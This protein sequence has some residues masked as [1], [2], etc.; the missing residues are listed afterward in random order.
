MFGLGLDGGDIER[1]DDD[2]F[3]MDGIDTGMDD[4]NFEAEE[5]VNLEAF[6]VPLRE[7]IAQDRT[8][9]EIQRKF[10][11]FVSTFREGEFDMD[12]DLHDDMHEAEVKRRKRIWAAKSP[13]YEDKIRIMCAANKSA[14]EVNYVHLSAK[15]PILALWINEAPKDM[16]DVLNEAATR[17]TLRLFPSYHTIRDEIHV[18]ISDVPLADSLRDMRHTHLDNLVKVSGVITRRSGVFPQLKLAYYDCVKCKFTTGPF[19]IE[20]STSHSSGLDGANRDVSDVHAPASCPE[21]QSEGPFRINSTRSRYRNYQRI[22]LQ[23]RPGS[24]PPG[25]VPRTK[26]VVFLDDLVD[27]A[28]PGEEVE[29]TGVFCHSYDSLLTQRSGFPV[30][31]TYISA[32][33]VRK[34]EDASSAANLSESDRKEILE[35]ARDTNIGKRIVQSIAPSIYGHDHV[36]MA[37]AMALFGAV[38]KNVD[39]KHRIRGD[40]NVLILGDPGTAKSQMLKYAEATAPRAVYST[41]KGASAVGLTANVHKDPL[42]REWTLEGGALVLADRGVCLIDEFDKMNEQDRTSIHEAMEQQTI[43]VSKAGIVTSLQARCSVI[44][45]ANPI[46]GRYDSSCTLAEN[47]ELT[48]PILQRFDCLCVLQDLVDPVAD[49]RLSSFVTKTHAT[50]IPTS[51]VARGVELAPERS[52]L[53]LGD[54]VGSVDLIPQSLLRKYIQYA[55]ANCR[56]ALRG[57]T[58]DQEK[59]ASLYVQ[60][61]K[62]STNSGGVPIAV[63]HI[64][65]IM[66]MAEAH[67]KMHLRDYVRDDDMDASIRI[68]LESFISAQK[69]SVR[70]TLR[71][72]F[73]K[74]LSSGEDRVHLLLHILQDMMRNEAMYQTI[75]QRQR[76][77]TGEIENLEVQLDEFEGKARERRIYDV[78]EFCKSDAFN[79]AGYTLD[80]SKRVISRKF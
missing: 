5:G 48:D 46:G 57:G 68:M 51:E 15:E 76:G 36:K 2:E 72:S 52:S 70:R 78:A 35:L 19:R 21:C 44:A 59:I 10:R 43:S 26:E 23:E 16:F 31:Q 29:I 65:S 25:R 24:I 53:E 28:R 63:R 45:A 61:R 11:V 3:G 49:E 79:E 47:V 54:G 71:R 32:N 41:G 55:R 42:T 80:F 4:D 58:F 67:A 40:V 77:E 69:F 64:E 1:E 13:T 56:P 34:K 27:C 73:G 9:R 39:D 60:L 17:H 74:F 8:R 38:P 37:L 75:R 33:H 12:E 7:W 62:E 20:D 30:F 66:R 18:R 14:L 22:N 50:S 6:D